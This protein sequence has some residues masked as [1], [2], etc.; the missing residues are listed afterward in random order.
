MA[1][2]KSAPNKA[3]VEVF[4][5][6]AEDALYE[7]IAHDAI[8]VDPQNPRKHFDGDGLSELAA[9]IAAD[10]LLEPLVVRPI[11]GSPGRFMLVAGER[12]WRAIGQAIFFGRWRLDRRV[13]SMVRNLSEPE[14][15]RLA[16]VENL[17]RR[18][19]NP[20]E[21]ARAIQALQEITG[22]SAAQIGRDLGFTE[23]WA[24]QRLSLL[25]L[26]EKLQ[27]R[28]DRGELKVEDARRA[29]A[30]WGKLP[31]IKQ[32]ELAR[33]AITVDVAKAW[34]DNQP[35]PLSPAA[36]LAIMELLEKREAHGF[37]PNHYST[38]KAVR[39]A[40]TTVRID[41]GDSGVRITVKPDADPHGALAELRQRYL[42][43]DPNPTRIE[44]V[45]TGGHHVAVNY[46]AEWN[47]KAVFAS[48][49][50]AKARARLIPTL[51]VEVYGLQA[52]YDASA[53]DGYATPWLNADEPILT[54]AMAE[55]IAGKRKARQAREAEAAAQRARED[56][57]R[58]RQ[59]Q[60]W[61]DLQAT[62]KAREAEIAAAEA[63][64][65]PAQ[66]LELA[67]QAGHPLPWAADESGNVRDAAGAVIFAGGGYWHGQDRKA[68]LRLILAV[69][70]AGAGVVMPAKPAA[71]LDPD[72]PTR[73]AFLAMIVGELLEAKDEA[74]E[75]AHTVGSATAA[76]EAG[77]A[78]F[79]R[80]EGIEYAD[81]NY[82]WTESGAN[83][84]ANGILDEGLGAQ[85][86]LE[87]AIT[88]GGGGGLAELVAD[89][90]PQEGDDAAFS[91]QLLALAG[92]KTPA[93][94]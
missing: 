40:A 31:P 71:A 51:R 20:L 22:T 32:V 57:A 3:L 28:L 81:E 62:A 52:D 49:L 53:A 39:I 29:A 68:G 76:A 25:E 56:D 36:Q 38:Q 30:I 33:G 18:D 43:D 35:Q 93:R 79:L 16:L 90:G 66:I 14:A 82:D 63:G 24:Q 80:D 15:R 37:E 27:G 60:A 83:A 88:A 4:G 77:L 91:P 5:R 58:R 23:R 41:N 87:D 67:A 26:P 21:E 94:A 19:L 78:A 12:R 70:N 46:S 92:V 54:P 2:A 7:E 69:A 59:A 64:E 75:P 50:D 65:R 9:S 61:V 45:E 34:L 48:A 86:D 17:Q 6:S 73:D 84:I 85:I 47:L 74:D 11:Q 89:P 8:T 72:A 55:E 10:G 44:D 1:K 13:P 42:V